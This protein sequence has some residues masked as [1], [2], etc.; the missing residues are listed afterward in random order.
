MNAGHNDS[1]RI[2]GTLHMATKRQQD[3]LVFIRKRFFSALAV[4]ISGLTC[5]AY[6]CTPPRNPL[7]SLPERKI[8]RFRIENQ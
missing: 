8:P 2:H 1:A 7:I 3:Y 4:S 5:A 6:L